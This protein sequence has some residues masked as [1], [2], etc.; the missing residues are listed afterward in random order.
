[1]PNSS[2][3]ENL[4]SPRQIE[5]LVVQSNPADTLL[6]VE[7]FHAAGLTTGLNCVTGEDAL[8]YVRGKGKYAHVPIPDLIFLDLS[9]PRVSGL[10]VLKV[11]KS[12][13]ELM[14]I[15]IVVAAGSDDPKFVRAVYALNGNCFIRKPGELPEFV[16]FI[17]S[18]YEFW[19]R[20]VTLSPQ[21]HTATYRVREPL[22]AIGN[23]LGT[24]PKFMTIERGYV[25]TVKGEVEQSEFVN[26][27]YEG[28]VV[29]V[30]MR[31]IENGAD[32]CG[33]TGRLTKRRP[34]I[35]Q[36]RKHLRS[37]GKSRSNKP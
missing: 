6:T 10:E 35:A 34:S 24:R 30:F 31:D 12:T 37:G 17:E 22:L 32:R 14:H 36:R 3:V 13:P 28:Q 11:M 2:H 25:I 19:S 1:M 33:R 29:K 7:A 8:S 27:S 15:P 20:V 26:V 5:V 18:C 21:P 23:D 4:A 16:R 9:Q